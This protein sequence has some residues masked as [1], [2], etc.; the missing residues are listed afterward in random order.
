L[1][2]FGC[3]LVTTGLHASQLF[4]LPLCEDVLIYAAH[5]HIPVAA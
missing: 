1:E 4:P 3:A 2:V 5:I